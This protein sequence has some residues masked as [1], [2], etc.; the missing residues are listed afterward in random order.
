MNDASD[1]SATSPYA[2]PFWEGLR[3][4]SFQLPQCRACGHFQFPMGPCC[5]VCLAEHFEWKVL[6]GRGNLW[7]Y[8]IYHHAYQ[9]NF[10]DRI[11]YVVALVTL[12]EGPRL[13]TNIVDCDHRELRN[14]LRVRAICAT[15][16]VGVVL[17]FRPDR[18]Q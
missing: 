8:V 16:D 18:D 14:G 3:N 5:S 6:S 4:G 12:D 17:R 2:A 9:P 15:E 11:P 7:S 13:I 10:A 1:P